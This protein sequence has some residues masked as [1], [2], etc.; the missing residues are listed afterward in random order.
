M[1]AERRHCI[2]LLDMRSR[3]EITPPIVKTEKVFK[4]W[5]YLVFIL[6]T[7]LNLTAIV[8]FCSY[9]F[10]LKAWLDYPI[11]F[12]VMT[13]V[14]TTHTSFYL[15]QWFLLPYM[16][17]P[18]PLPARPGWKVGVATTFVPGAE[19]LE[20]LE[21]TVKALVAMD[22]P[23]DTWVLDEGNN[24][25]VMALCRR[26]G[27]HHFSRRNLP[28]Y[29]SEYGVFRARTKHGNYNAWLYEIGFETYE[30]ITAFDPDHVPCPNYLSKVLGYFDDTKIGYV[31]VAQAYYNQ[32][33]SFIARGAAEETYAYYSS[34]QM[35]CYTMGYPIVTGCHNTHRVTSL[36]QVGGFAPHDADDL[37]IT[38]FYRAQGWQ[39]VYIPEVLA[40]GLTP[41][42]WPGYCIQQ[43]RW[44]RSVLDIKFRIYPKFALELP[45]KTRL[46]SFLQGLNYIQEGLMVLV[47]TLLLI[48]ML[49]IGTT[50]V[51]SYLFGKRTLIFFASLQLCDF[52]RQRFFLDWRNEAG[53]PWRA[54]LVRFAK[55]PYILRGLFEAILNRRVPYQLTA[56]VKSKSRKYVLIQPHMLIV[57]LVCAAWVIGI[58]S[59]KKVDT[60]VHIWT[61]VIVI[62]ELL[63]VLTEFMDFP[64]PYDKNLLPAV[65]PS[66]EEGWRA[67]DVRQDASPRQ[68]ISPSPKSPS[69]NP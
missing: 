46:I 64:D 41:V 61:T 8:S 4:W 55:W 5:D 1:P 69:R 66:G 27:A 28:Q 31:Q 21:E 17:K 40:R 22:Y 12:L 16:R 10:G 45:L 14:L 50:P 60:S 30:I 68:E 49:I 59:G 23:H 62:T 57:T 25:E 29:Q 13:L 53:F 65:L 36:K 47:G 58:F 7:G 52:Y 34:V 35:A 11:T 26:L 18:Q 51:L 67:G 42:D 3:L 19:S 9:W 54:A 37:L 32:K 6:L 33:A 43:L 48:F 2:G 38:V 15:F 63:L 20:M 56:K 24:D 39:G 44:A